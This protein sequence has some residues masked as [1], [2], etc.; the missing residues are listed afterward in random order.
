MT[1]QTTP[2][3]EFADQFAALGNSLAEEMLAIEM[4]QEHGYP[5]KEAESRAARICRWANAEDAELRAKGINPESEAIA[6]F[7][8]AFYFICTALVLLEKRGYAIL[9]RKEATKT[10]YH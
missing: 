7:R 8:T 3:E 6:D 2:E 1:T 4:T 9:V 5:K 10:T